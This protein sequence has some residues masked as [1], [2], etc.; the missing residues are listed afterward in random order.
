MRLFLYGV[1]RLM[2]WSAAV[3][4]AL[5]PTLQTTGTMPSWHLQGTMLAV[6]SAGHF[7]DLFFIIVPASAVSLSTTLDF[8]CSKPK[9][10]ITGL[11]VVIAL[12]VNMMVLLS[13]FVGFALIPN[14]AK[15]LPDDAFSLY[16]WLITVGLIITLGTE[17]WISGFAASERALAQARLMHS[18]SAGTRAATVAADTGTPGNP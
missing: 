12:I 5:F 18:G 6:N 2:L 17:L 11:L 15:V 8:L 13:G 9:G 10:E 4:I 3:F 16:S 14:D 1:I 7:R